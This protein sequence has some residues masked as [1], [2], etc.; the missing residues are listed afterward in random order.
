MIEVYGR[1]GCSYCEKAIDILERY[2]AKYSYYKLGR[3]LTAA[4]FKEKFPDQ[5][6][7]PCV[8]VHGM[9]IGG[10]NEL[11]GYLEETSGGYTDDI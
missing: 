2:K 11:A 5:K 9:K 7:V 8:V 6:T 3:D 4:E 1:D 10:Y